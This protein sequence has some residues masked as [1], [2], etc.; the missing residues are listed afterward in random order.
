MRFHE[1]FDK[2]HDDVAVHWSKTYFGYDAFFDFDGETYVI[3]LV[4][5]NP[6]PHARS[7]TM[8][9]VYAI[10]FGIMKNGKPSINTT[11]MNK[12]MDVLGIVANSVVDHLKTLPNYPEI[13]LVKISTLPQDNTPEQVKKRKRIYNVL[14]DKVIAKLGYK[15]VTGWV[16]GETIDTTVYSIPELKPYEL[17]KAFKALSTKP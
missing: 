14:M 8:Y 7:P 12:P 4:D 1:I 2:K 10:N 9:N 11:S 6:N 15:D 5:E 16:S 3:N 17:R 13:L